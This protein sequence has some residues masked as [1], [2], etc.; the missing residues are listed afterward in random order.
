MVTA[1]DLFLYESLGLPQFYNFST[2]T[3]IVNE[4]QAFM[5]CLGNVSC[6]L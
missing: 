1:V 5:V 2:Y 4:N 6:D 3:R